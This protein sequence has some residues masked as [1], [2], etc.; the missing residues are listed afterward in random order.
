MTTTTLVKKNIQLGMAYRFRDLVPL[1]GSMVTH[2][3]TWCW[4]RC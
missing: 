4:R 3:Q 2:R 1:L